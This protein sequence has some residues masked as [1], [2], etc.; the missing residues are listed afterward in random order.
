MALQGHIL[1]LSLKHLK[2]TFGLIN[3]IIQTNLEDTADLLEGDSF[4]EQGLEMKRQRP[5]DGVQRAT[6]LKAHVKRCK[7]EDD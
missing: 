6:S 5:G 3:S 1:I 2:I 7:G 4:G